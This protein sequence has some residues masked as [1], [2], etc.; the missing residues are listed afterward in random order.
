[1]AYSEGFKSEATVAD[2]RVADVGMGVTAWG[3]GTTPDVAV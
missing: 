2:D 1:M 3:T